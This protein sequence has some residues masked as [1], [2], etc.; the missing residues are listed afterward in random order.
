MARQGKNWALRDSRMEVACD[1]G[2][3]RSISQVGEGAGQEGAM[4]PCR[5]P[6][7]TSVAGGSRQVWVPGYK[8]GVGMFVP[9][10]GPSLRLGMSA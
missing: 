9:A 7:K 10:S 6:W 5:N 4:R 2:Q 3:E 8:A 1:L